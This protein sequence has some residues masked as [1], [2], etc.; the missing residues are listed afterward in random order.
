MLLLC[1]SVY[2]C[3]GNTVHAA[4]AS[5]IPGGRNA[6]TPPPLPNKGVGEIDIFAKERVGA[7]RVRM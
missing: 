5:G 6:P 4:L 1:N 7:E 2:R 3:G